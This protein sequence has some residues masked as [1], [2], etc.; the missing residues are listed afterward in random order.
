MAGTEFHSVDSDPR[1]WH[2]LRQRAV[3]FSVQPNSTGQPQT[4]NGHSEW[5]VDNREPR[6]DVHDDQGHN[7][8]SPY[9]RYRVGTGCGTGAHQTSESANSRCTH[10]KLLLD[11]TEVPDPPQCKWRSSPGDNKAVV[12]GLHS[13]SYRE[14]RQLAELSSQ[15]SSDYSLRDA[16]SQHPDSDGF[17]I[18]KP[19]RP[20][21]A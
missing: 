6:F 20:D 4:W 2:R 14:G 11:T 19:L 5:P 16:Q 8:F 15:W 21:R 12:P 18:R 1:N 9:G 7:R 13:R 3:R 17:A 10:R